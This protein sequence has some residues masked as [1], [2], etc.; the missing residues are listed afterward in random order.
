MYLIKDLYPD[1]IRSSYTS[2]TGSKS[3][4]FN[5]P[6]LLNCVFTC[7]LRYISCSLYPI[8]PNDTILQN[9]STMSQPGNGHW[10][11]IR[12]KDRTFPPPQD[13]LIFSPPGTPLRLMS[14]QWNLYVLHVSL[15]K[16]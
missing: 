9:Y 3:F 4:I 14:E 16:F 13:S 6:F 11:L 5:L 1:Y 10:T 7:S 15:K 12:S 8:S 2:V